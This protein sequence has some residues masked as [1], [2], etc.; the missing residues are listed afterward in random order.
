VSLK[1]LG[2]E[3]LAVGYQPKHV[4]AENVQCIKIICA[5]VGNKGKV[6]P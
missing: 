1:L 2:C 3:L 5:F 6:K 4:A